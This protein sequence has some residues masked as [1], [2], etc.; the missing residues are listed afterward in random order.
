MTDIT[1]WLQEYD[2]NLYNVTMGYFGPPTLYDETT[3][4]KLNKIGMTGFYFGFVDA[5]QDNA[6]D[7]LPADD[8]LATMIITGKVSRG[9]AKITTEV[10][11][12]ALEGVQAGGKM[13]SILQFKDT[14]VDVQSLISLGNLN[15]HPA[16]GTQAIIGS[17]TTGFLKA[18][19]TFVS[20]F[21]S[22]DDIIQL[23]DADWTDGLEAI[24]DYITQQQRV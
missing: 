19:T 16:M 13:H 9:T 4:E 14:V 5:G 20:R 18:V 7:W 3:L 24:Q 1:Q 12:A 23:D 17:P 15:K 2:E 8:R 11:E 10:Y 21:A 6:P 22:R